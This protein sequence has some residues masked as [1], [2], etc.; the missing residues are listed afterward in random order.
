[1]AV[2]KQVSVALENWSLNRAAE[3]YQEELQLL[4]SLGR[5]LRETFDLKAQVHILRQTMKDLLAGHDFSLAIQEFPGGPLEVAVSF[6]QEDSHQSAAEAREL[7]EQVVR[8]LSPILICE[9]W[10]WAPYRS[11]SRPN[12][13]QMCTW[14]GVPIH[15]SDETLGV[16][17]VASFQRERAITKEQF[18]L[19]KVLAYEAAGA[20]ENALAFKKEQ[21][22]ASHLAVLNEIGRKLNS[23]MNPKEILPSICGLVGS[24]FGHEFVR[25]EVMD[26]QRQELIVV[27][28]SGYG[29]DLIGRRIRMDE[30]LSGAAAETGEPVLANSV[31]SEPRYSAINQKVRS[32]L[33]LPLRFHD[34]LLGTMSFENCRQNAFA[35]QDVLTLQALADQMANALYNAR[36]YEN[37]R[38]ESIDRQ[39]V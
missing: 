31:E 11:A 18:E 30:G 9:D 1:M 7:E 25:F 6:L 5:P 37:A 20:F 19:I 26:R 15:F 33:S 17:S 2:G 12:V 24:S 23:V 32:A 27:A 28:E 38:E 10:Q 21:Q 13:P 34:E 14:C 35:P 29:N 22:R 8:T 16:F 3:K 39:S 4:Y 36:A